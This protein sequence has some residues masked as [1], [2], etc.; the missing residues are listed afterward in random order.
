MNRMLQFV[1][2]AVLLV[3]SAMSVAAQSDRNKFEF[4][5]GY[6]YLRT[7]TGLDED[8]EDLDVDSNFNSHGFNASLTGNVHRY[9]GLKADFSTHSKSRSFTDGT[10]TASIKFRTNQFLGGLQF[11]DNK[12]D[13]KRVKPFAHVLAGV[14]N[15]KITASGSYIIPEG[16]STTFDDSASTNNFAMV[17]GAGIDVKVSKRVDIRIIQFDYNPIFFREQDFDDF[18]LAGRTQNNFRIGVGI[19]IH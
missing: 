11:K 6:S 10:D 14:A 1:T 13:G 7:D 3:F 4:Y 17:F 2:V 5:G 12:V 16:G 19:V 15:Q 9:V 8:L 18:T